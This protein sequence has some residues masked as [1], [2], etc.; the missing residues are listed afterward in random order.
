MPAATSNLFDRLALGLIVAVLAAPITYLEVA[1]PS[2]QQVSTTVHGITSHFP[3]TGT[4]APST[5]ATSTK[6]PTATVP[7][8]AK[9]AAKTAT[10]N[11]YVHLRAAKS[12]NS[13]VLSNI[14]SGISV[15]LTGDADPTWQGVT[16]QGKTGYIYRAYLTY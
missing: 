4:T 3:H 5:P 16:Y 8:T 10:T 15:Q 6:T 14:A 2:W 11:S 1:R 7:S 9:P 12:V 13:A